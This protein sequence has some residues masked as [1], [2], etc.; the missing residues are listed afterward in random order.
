MAWAENRE[1]KELEDSV[2]CLLGLLNISMPLSYGEGKAKAFSR[3]REELQSTNAAPSIIPFSMNDL[4]VA[5]PELAEIEAE[6]LTSEQTPK[7]TIT[8]E[9]GTGKSQLALEIAHKIRQ[10]NKRC[11]VFWID[12][13]SVDSLYQ[14]YS[15]IA[16][17][18][19]IPGWEDDKTDVI[20]MVK[21]Y[22]SRMSARP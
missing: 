4:F 3:L 7:V 15:S 1:T 22:L 2:Y 16:Q 9:G 6:L 14:A 5:R 20:L 13:S 8:G 18:L 10:E 19:K 17:K 11:S 12:A 21:N